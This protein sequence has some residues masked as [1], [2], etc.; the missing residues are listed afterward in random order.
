MGGVI[1]VDAT[2]FGFT[3]PLPLPA[4]RV[5]FIQLL[6]PTKNSYSLVFPHSYF[7]PDQQRLYD[8]SM[9]SFYGHLFVGQHKR[10]VPLPTERGVSTVQD[11]LYSP[12]TTRAVPLFRMERNRGSGGARI[13]TGAIDWETGGQ[14]RPLIFFWGGEF[15]F[16]AFC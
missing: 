9:F 2:G 3:L 5:V 8:A 4:I 7:V 14:G 16:C 1:R 6:L 13:G 12:C 10:R 15:L 11:A